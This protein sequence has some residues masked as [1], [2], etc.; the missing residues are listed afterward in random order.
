MLNTFDTEPA[1]EE[2]A[3]TEAVAQ[4]TE[5]GKEIAL[6]AKK[7]PKSRNMI[8]I[9]KT[10]FISLMLAWPI[11]HMLIFWA[12]V[13]V[14]SIALGF[15]NDSGGLTLEH[16]GNFFKAVV[17]TD[18]IAFRSIINSLWSFAFG[19]GVSFPTSLVLAYFMFK[20][21]PWSRFFRTVYFLPNIISAVVLSSIYYYLLQ[22]V[23]PVNRFLGWFGIRPIGFLTTE[24]YVFMS[25]LFYGFWTGRGMDT[26]LLSG[27]MARIPEDIMDYT[28]LEGVGFVREFFQIILPLIFDTVSSILIMSATG[29]FTGMGMT[30]LLTA[31]S[32]LASFT[33]TIGYFIYYCVQEDNLQYASAAG[34]VFS[35]IAVPLIMA[36]R[37]VLGKVSDGIEF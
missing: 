15:Q 21:V 28:R 5:S 33:S 24:R 3:S 34:L 27:A 18:D 17:K 9:R 22:S 20:G 4:G 36:L 26:L 2:L 16:F 31:G 11:I 14:D 7:K 13:Q 1:K 19:L 10:I 30:L 6:Q 32:G 12:Y 23:G 35:L 37:K 8:K 29:V 25:C